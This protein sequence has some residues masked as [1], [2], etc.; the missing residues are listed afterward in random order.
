MIWRNPLAWAALPLLLLPL[1]IHLLTRR[2]AGVLRF[3]TLRFLADLP[4]LQSRRSRP[5][6]LL[7]LAV[8]VAALLLAIAALAQ[9]LLMTG[10]R[11]RR[12][13]EYLSRVI[14]VDT[15]FSMSRLSPDGRRAMDVAL[16][17]AEMLR[18]EASAALVVGSAAPA[19]ELSAAAEWL[20]LQ[21]GRKEL[22][23]LSDFQLGTID[24]TA[25]GR[26]ADNVAL[27]M[28]VLPLAADSTTLVRSV[29]FPESEARGEARIVAAASEVRWRSTAIA[30]PGPKR[31]GIGYGAPLLLGSAED[32]GAAH[33]ALAAALTLGV[34]RPADRLNDIAVVLAGYPGREDLLRGARALSEPWMG[35]VVARVRRD[36]LPGSPEPTPASDMRPAQG[37]SAMTGA[38]FAPLTDAAAEGVAAYAAAAEIGATTRL[39]VFTDA[40]AG[41]LDLARLTAALV[42]AASAAPPASELD[43]GVADSAQIAALARGAATTAARGDG[44]SPTESDGRWFW[45]PVL[46]LLLMEG[47]LRAGTR[48]E[49]ESGEGA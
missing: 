12:S 34:A 17:R 11:S 10:D 29:R 37:G 38:R 3:P 28:V 13:D 4:P 42:K 15:S 20:G 45:L 6:H 33:A 22:V 31:P 40:R 41:T 2:R 32:E 27:E 8:R 23:L 39:V 35:E 26:I 19:L 47:W 21:R 46:L 24:S 49:R 16:E 9:P 44:L 7:I 30:A 18:R 1:V 36:G 14:V 5:S 25:L 48:A 43:P